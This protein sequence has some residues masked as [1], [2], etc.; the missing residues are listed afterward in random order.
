MPRICTIALVLAT[1]VLAACGGSDDDEKGPIGSADNPVQA[2]PNPSN[3]RIPPTEQPPGE[4]AATRPKDEQVQPK[5]TASTRTQKG[6]KDPGL[7]RARAKAK[8]KADAKLTTGEPTRPKTARKQKALA[9]SAA[10]PCSLVTKAQARA[11]IGVPI[12]EPLEA[13]QGPTCIYRA[14]SGTRFITV[15]VETVRFA[16]LRRQISKIRRVEV[17]TAYCG[18][19]GRPMLYLPLSS[20]RVLS[21]SAP[22][23]L[24]TRFAA[25]AAPHL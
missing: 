24:A 11:I 20:T 9:P 3:T 7:A 1:G 6:T 2:V 5:S 21:V 15:A 10:R 23:G 16:Q 17:S 13:P 4:V 12:V 22:C 19:H 25:K 18:R 8:A 14:K